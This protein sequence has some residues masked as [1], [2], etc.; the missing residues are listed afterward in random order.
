MTGSAPSDEA[1]S[2]EELLRIDGPLAWYGPEM[3]ARTDWIHHFSATELA[4]LE[5]AVEGVAATP[6]LD[7]D[8][9]RFALPTLG[10][11][12]Q[13]LQREVMDGRGFVLLRGISV[14]HYS[15]EQAAR[16][17]FG[18]GQWLGEPISQN[19]EGHM[20]GHVKDIGARVGNP[21]Q[22]GYQSPDALPFHNDVAGDMVALFC[23]RPARSGGLSSIVSGTTLYNELLERDPA[24]VRALM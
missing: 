19:P 21:N 16:L 24:L 18:L 6:I 12:L 2:N 4:E 8:R 3:A 13:Q 1:V 14:E 15:L 7:I 20:L 23:L 11:T 22:R 17:Y 5:R 9:E 10:P